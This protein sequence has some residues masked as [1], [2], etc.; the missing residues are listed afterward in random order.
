MKIMFINSFYNEAS[1]GKIVF[2]T[3]SYLDKQIGIESYACYGRG[4]KQSD[5]RVYRICSELYCKIGIAKGLIT[6]R[7][8]SSRAIATNR[9]KKYISKIQPDIIHLHCL[10]SYFVDMYDLMR[11][12]KKKKIKT[13]LTLHAEYMYTGGCAHTGYALDCIKFCDEKG[14][15]DCHAKVMKYFPLIDRSHQNWRDMLQIYDCYENLIITAVSPWLQGRAKKSYMLRDKDVRLVLNGID[16]SIFRYIQSDSVKTKK[17]ILHVTASFEA[18]IKG[19]Q[20]VREL[21]KKFLEVERTDVQ[22]IIIGKTNGSDIPSN[23]TV[24]GPI[25]DQNKLAKWYSCA[26]ITLLT[27]KKETFSMICAESL[28]CGTPV[29][30][31]KAGAPEG[32]SIERYSEFV[33]F[34]DAEALFGSVNRWLKKDINKEEIS[35]AGIQTFSCERMAKQYFDIYNE[36]SRV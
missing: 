19:G 25:F 4:E 35:D 1:T 23:M 20:Y 18:E 7:F 2:D 10:N 8:Y 34:G 29:I 3:I 15:Y 17:I 26:D 36:L 31:F 6:G 22:F 30:G 9:I 32:I 21:A 24:L 11:F 14:C 33:E 13:V 28:C 12:I 16:T 5:S 27:S